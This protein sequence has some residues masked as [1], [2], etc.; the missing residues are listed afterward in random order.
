MDPPDI[1][2]DRP[3]ER[4]LADE[5][6]HAPK[7]QRIRGPAD[8]VR[9]AGPEQDH[10]VERAFRLLDLSHGDQRARRARPNA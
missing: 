3:V 6:E 2:V 10:V 7:R 8:D 1:E 4:L 5:V 9:R